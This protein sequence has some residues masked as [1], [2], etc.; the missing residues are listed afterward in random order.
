[1]TRAVSSDQVDSSHAP[2]ASPEYTH[3]WIARSRRRRARRVMGRGGITRLLLG[4]SIFVFT[5]PHSFPCLSAASR[6]FPEFPKSSDRDPRTALPGRRTLAF[7]VALSTAA[8]D[9]AS[10]PPCS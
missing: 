7:T 4:R 6:E 10:P 3:V 5:S 9:D 2:R 1:M 8:V